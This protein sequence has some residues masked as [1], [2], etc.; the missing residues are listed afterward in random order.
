MFA[1]KVKRRSANV[2]ECEQEIHICCQMFHM[3]V[4]QNCTDQI[5][6]ENSRDLDNLDAKITICQDLLRNSL[7]S[8]RIPKKI[9]DNIW[10]NL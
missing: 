8:A 9:P 1:R 3:I 10:K 4:R 5:L 2:L 7:K 6:K